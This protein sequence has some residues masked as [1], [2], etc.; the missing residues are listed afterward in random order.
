[1]DAVRALSLLRKGYGKQG[2]QMRLYFVNLL[3]RRY[4]KQRLQRSLSSLRRTLTKVHS[5][6]IIA[7]SL[8]M[9][10]RRHGK[11]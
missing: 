6:I 8:S 2:A 5:L 3:K 7:W 1:M 10:K 4:R 9:T 11:R